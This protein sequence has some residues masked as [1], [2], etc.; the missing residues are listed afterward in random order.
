[1]VS[2]VTL[3]LSLLGAITSAKPESSLAIKG[4]HGGCATTHPENFTGQREHVSP[5]VQGC[6][7][8]SASRLSGRRLQASCLEGRVD[9]RLCAHRGGSRTDSAGNLWPS[10]K[11]E[12]WTRDHMGSPWGSSAHT[13]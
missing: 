1:M 5:L 6:S 2:P 9:V 11:G 12:P 3:A 7:V 10:P 13:W 4:G 8:P